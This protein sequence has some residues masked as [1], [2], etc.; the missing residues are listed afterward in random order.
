MAKVMWPWCCCC[1]TL[2]LSQLFTSTGTSY[3]DHWPPE[4]HSYTFHDILCSCFYEIY[5]DELPDSIVVALVPC[6]LP[7]PHLSDGQFNVTWKLHP[8]SS[9]V[10]LIFRWVSTLPLVLTPNCIMVQTKSVESMPTEIQ[11]EELARAYGIKVLFWPSSY[12]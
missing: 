6:C 11:R 9:V 1:F 2:S 5:L 12:K 8:P 7:L 4:P 10:S 3:L